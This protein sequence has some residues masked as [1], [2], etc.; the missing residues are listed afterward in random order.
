MAPLLVS[1]AIFN[2]GILG[3]LFELERGVAIKPRAW[4]NEVPRRGQ[5]SAW[6]GR[7]GLGNAMLTPAVIKV[8]ALV[9]V[10]SV[11]IALFI[12]LNLFRARALHLSL[13]GRI[14]VALFILLD[15]GLTRV[16]TWVCV[17]A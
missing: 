15:L 8:A 7:R 3:T 2:Q 14:I 10:R 6:S 13:D 1:A 17:G 16:C 11:V 12:L 4:P 5:T 9:F